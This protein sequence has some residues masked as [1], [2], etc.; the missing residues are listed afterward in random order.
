M[1]ISLLFLRT[2]RLSHHIFNP[3]YYV[4]CSFL[5][6]PIFFQPLLYTSGRVAW[7]Y[8]LTSV[9]QSSQVSLLTFDSQE[10]FAIYTTYGKQNS[11]DQKKHIFHLNINFSKD[12][13]EIKENSVVFI[14]DF[15][16]RNFVA[17]FVI[18][19]SR[20]HRTKLVQKPQ[21]DISERGIGA[22]QASIRESNTLSNILKQNEGNTS[23]QLYL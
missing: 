8:P 20:F 13:C 3:F 5:N 12:S 7:L 9:P 17:K 16:A 14:F 6:I 10:T 4:S 2:Q 21:K 11:H 22:R 1:L 18:L 15:R 19:V 23:P